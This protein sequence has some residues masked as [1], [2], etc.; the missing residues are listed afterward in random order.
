MTKTTTARAVAK[1]EPEPT[2]LLAL[3][4]SAV[5]D[6]AVDAAKMR[7]LLELHREVEG[8]MDRREFSRHMSQLQSEISQIAADASNPSTNSRY[9]SYPALDRALR[10]Y[11]TTHGFTIGFDVQDS[12]RGADWLNVTCTVSRGTYSTKHTA[13]VHADQLGPKGNKVMTAT[14]AAGSALSYGKRYSLAMAFAI[15]VE[16]D[17]DGNA[18]SARNI[19]PSQV[20]ELG[21]LCRQCDVD[22]AKVCEALEISSIAEIT[23]IQFNKVKSRI[24]AT[25]KRKEVV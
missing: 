14:H 18:A 21:Q 19:T 11:W 1:R 24:L 16:R 4:A 3:I 8:D 20:A 10:P 12:T 13:P 17:D 25:G 2:S 23:R 9:A 15:A 5:R 7:D 6:P 22:V